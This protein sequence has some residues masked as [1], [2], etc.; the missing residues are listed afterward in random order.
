MSSLP[1][2]YVTPQQYLEI[3]RKAEHK[4]EYVDGQMY[5]MSGVS[6]SH[7]R[8]T[9]DIF[10][11]LDEQLTDGPCEVFVSKIRVRPKTGGPY[12]YPDVIVVCGE[13]KFE[14]H[15]F[16]TLLNPKVIVEVLSPSTEP[17]DRGKKFEMY[18]QMPSLAEYILIAQDHIH[19]EH[20]VLQ[21]SGTWEFSET[22]DAESIVEL[23]S[24]GARLK[25]ADIY[26]RVSAAPQGN[27]RE[28]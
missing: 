17:Y 9:L 25:V 23:P 6:R 19:V 27:L 21:G 11:R 22:R 5:A 12:Y 2:P 7:N 4:S 16:D 1:S 18:R 8:I 14:D 3:E 24:V 26:R 10:L 28:V 20:Y 13:Q 15:E